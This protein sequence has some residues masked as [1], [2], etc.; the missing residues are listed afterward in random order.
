MQATQTRTDLLD[1]LAHN[2]WPNGDMNLI[3]V[4][5]YESVLEGW[6]IQFPAFVAKPP[7]FWTGLMN[8]MT[9]RGITDAFI[10]ALAGPQKDAAIATEWETFCNSESIA[11]YN[12]E[13]EGDL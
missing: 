7:P 12:N 1:T 8:W 3:A 9:G 2:R 10:N 4:V 13:N 5:W 6:A 11:P